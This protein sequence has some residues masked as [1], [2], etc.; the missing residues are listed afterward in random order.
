MPHAWFWH[1][2]L[3]GVLANVAVLAMVLAIAAT[4][5]SLTT[6]NTD[7]SLDI[8]SSTVVTAILL[9]HLVRRLVETVS[10]M[11]R[12]PY[13]TRACHSHRARDARGV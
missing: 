13:P 12:A 6:G 1:F 11:R 9:T 10:I 8:S 4:Q 3:V 5:P 7:L 2:Y